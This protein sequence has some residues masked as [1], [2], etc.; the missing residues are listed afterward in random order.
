[1][2]QKHWMKTI[3]VL[4]FFIRLGL[5]AQPPIP[6]FENNSTEQTESG[7]IK[8]SWKLGGQQTGG[9]P[10]VFELQQAAH[11]D[12]NQ[13]TLVYKG[14]DYATFQSGLSDGDYFYRVRTARTDGT[15]L[16]DWST[17]VL[18]RVKHHS[19]QLAFLLFGIGATVFLITVGIVLQ[20]AFRF[21]NQRAQHDNEPPA[22]NH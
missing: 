17:P 11:Q 14:P 13:T 5:A 22:Q 16:S 10:I 18:L 4:M 3:A 8:L 20:G 6:V 19:L 7:Y 12:F 21:A 2:N 1:M 15:P 9:D